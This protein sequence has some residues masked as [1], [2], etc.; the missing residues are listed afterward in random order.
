MRVEL[1][2]RDF[3]GHSLAVRAQGL[4]YLTSFARIV[5]P[6]DNHAIT[7]PSIIPKTISLISPPRCVLL[8]LH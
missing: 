5:R 8:E 1:T 7:C 4:V 3:A 6:I 2:I